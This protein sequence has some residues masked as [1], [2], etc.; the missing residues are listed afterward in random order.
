MGPFRAASMTSATREVS[1][2]FL[3]FCSVETLLASHLLSIAVART[4]LRK[5]RAL[6][7]QLRL[8]ERRLSLKVDMNF[9]ESRFD[10]H[11]KTF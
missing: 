8:H 1:H 7:G 3:R 10:F 4:L 6:L 2:A 11:W 9:N 5:S